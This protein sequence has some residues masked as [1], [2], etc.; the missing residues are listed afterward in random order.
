MLV[1]IAFMALRWKKLGSLLYLD[2]PRWLHEFSRVARGELP[3]RDFSFQYPPFAAFLYG[4][5][6]RWFG[7]TF[8]TAQIVTDIVSALV[9]VLCAAL[10][11]RLLPPQLRLA[12][13]LCVVA[14]CGTSLMFFNLFSFVTYIPSLQTGAVGMLI[15]LL[16]LLGY[17]RE[18]RLSGVGW[19]ML[20]LGGLI[21]CLS[22]PEF[23]I[24]SI[25]AVVAAA[26]LRPGV[27]LAL[28]VAAVIF[29]PSLA[30]YALLG[31]MVGWSEL[32]AA[33][34]GYGLA[35]ASCPW[36]P[37]GLG[38]FGA[39]AAL[40]QASAIA[41]LVSLPQRKR[42]ANLYG[43]HY[44]RL[45]LGGL[46]GTIIYAAYIAYR[47]WNTLIAPLTLTERVRRIAPS[48]LFTSPVLEPV[49]WAAVVVFVVLVYRW[50]RSRALEGRDAE[51]LLVL[52]VT[53]AMAS[54]SIFGSTQSEFPEVAGVCY[55]FFIVLGACFLWRFLSSAATPR[56][57]AGVVAAMLLAY[58]G[59]RVAA[60][61][62]EMLSNRPYGALQTAAGTVRVLNYKI[63]S[64]VYQYVM[65]HTT[66]DDYLLEVPYGGGLN[67]STGRRSPIYTT[68]LEGMG[69]APDYQ[70]RDLDLFLRHPAALVIAIDRPAL[71]TNWSFGLVG[72][73]MCACPRLVWEPDQPNWRPNYV[74]PLIRYVQEHYHAA[75]KIGD[76]VI[77]APNQALRASRSAARIA[78]SS[79]PGTPCTLRITKRGRR[80]TSS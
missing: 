50:A 55:P 30:I 53:L 36:W 59:L 21:G 33:I 24:G 57:A 48:L 32:R 31:K 43:Q 26:A 56:Y 7:V 40:G 42:F 2:P 58:A 4:W 71:G 10:I 63:D 74:Y 3:Y 76:K 17:V 61:W 1:C 51:L 13:A 62:P 8:N 12:T 66:P 75:A 52:A 80:F 27:K 5:A 28:R 22:K 20:A 77:L 64:T 41:A 18:G 15:V 23:V 46:A 45:L 60:A 35:T 6:L 39:A 69:W 72:N 70:Q 38:I 68:Q 16:A 25:A 54:R 37:T 79:C 67:F 65:A 11:A 14:V 47:N 78:D 44:S 29:L 19:T 73:R 34:G 9:V 49:L